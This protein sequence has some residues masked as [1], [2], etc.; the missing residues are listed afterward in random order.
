MDGGTFRGI[1]VAEI[2]NKLDLEIL[3]DRLI[4]LTKL[5]ILE[6]EIKK[7][8]ETTL[9]VMFLSIRGYNKYI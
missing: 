2:K 3:E 8:R 6:K 1:V 7:L 4:N 5:V 9:R